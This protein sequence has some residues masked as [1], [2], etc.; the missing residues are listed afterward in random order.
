M[1]VP[2]NI[3]DGQVSSVDS[4]SSACSRL[5]NW[6]LDASGVNT[7]RPR[8]V[9]RSISNIGTSPVIGACKWREYTVIVCAN[10]YIGIIN[11]LVPDYVNWVSTSDTATQL[12]GSA[13]RPTFA[14]GDESIFIAG[15]G[16]IQKWNPGLG[17]SAVVSA[18]PRCTHV[19]SIANYLLANSV[20]YPSRIWWSD[21]GEG[22]WDTWPAANFR[23]AEARP[24]PVLAV[25]ENAYN[26]YV[27]GS[28]T[29]EVYGIGSDP[30]LP[31]E[32]TNT[33]NRGIA[34]P[35]ACCAMDEG[36]AYLD[37]QRQIVVGS[38]GQVQPLSDAIKTD[39]RGF[40]D[41]SDCWMYREEI[42]SRSNLVVRFPAEER[43]FVH[44]FERQAWSERQYYVSPFLTDW[45]VS[46]ATYVPNTNTW[47]FGST[48][49]GMYEFDMDPGLEL[50]AP[51]VC[52]R[53]T[54][55]HDFSTSK[56]KRSRGLQLVLR[57]GTAAQG[58]VPG[59]YEIRVQSDDSAWSPWYQVS[60]GAPSDHSQVCRL[61]LGGVFRRRRYGIRFSTT[62]SAAVVSLADDV[63]ELAHG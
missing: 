63:Q 42:G 46:S 62:E 11:D 59:A 2:I 40:D 26:V 50:G 60:V 49:A 47:L 57:R 8:L 17:M 37:N 55:W 19:I 58:A 39:L 16:R 3:G 41:V 5:V 32:I 24:D 6:Q 56:R 18:S 44:D 27:F 22:A 53:T 13:P 43:T 21:I 1:L 52:E 34:A 51:L 33:V 28:E 7:P 48:D 35:Y 23:T 20:D 61:F 45:P 30:T 9:T 29:L 36:F 10:R 25:Y 12:E 54:G 31:F 4:L 14:M 38:G 15:G